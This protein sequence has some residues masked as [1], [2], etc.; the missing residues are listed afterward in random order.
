MAC[1]N[2]GSSNPDIAGLGVKREQYFLYFGFQWFEWLT[3]GWEQIILSFV[4]QG[5]LSFGLSIWSAN[6]D[7]KLAKTGFPTALHELRTVLYNLR[8]AP[9]SLPVHDIKNNN[10]EPNVGLISRRLKKWY[11]D[12]L[13]ATISDVQTLNGRG[14]FLKKKKKRKKE[15]NNTHAISL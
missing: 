8:T 10:N 15:I 11:M 5:G 3:C 14:F 2:V 9:F 7:V 6:L 13:L 1:A 12:Q 4:I